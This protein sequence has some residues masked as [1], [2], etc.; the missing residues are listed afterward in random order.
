MIGYTQPPGL[1]SDEAWHHDLKCDVE[2]FY[3]AQNENEANLIEPQAPNPLKYL[4]HSQRH[5]VK[6]NKTINRL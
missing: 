1:G 5:L 4:V 2:P 6:N 3:V